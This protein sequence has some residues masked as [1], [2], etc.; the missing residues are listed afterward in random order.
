[1]LCN[2]TIPQGD[3]FIFDHIYKFGY[4]RWFK[5]I[6]YNNI[7]GN[8]SQNFPGTAEYNQYIDLYISYA[9]RQMA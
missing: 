5:F 2:Y 9:I 3:M 4:G 7:V 6:I 1:M 8:P